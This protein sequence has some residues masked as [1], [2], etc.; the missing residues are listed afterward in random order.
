LVAHAHDLGYG[1]HRQSIAVGGP[2]GVIPLD[3]QLLSG[4]RKGVVTI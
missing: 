2:D 1:R 3:A 4:L